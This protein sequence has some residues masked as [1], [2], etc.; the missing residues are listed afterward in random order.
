MLCDRS[1]IRQYCLP[2]LNLIYPLVQPIFSNIHYYYQFS[3]SHDKF[4]TAEISPF[5]SADGSSNTYSQY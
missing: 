4:Q 1:D 2:I 3:V 5:K